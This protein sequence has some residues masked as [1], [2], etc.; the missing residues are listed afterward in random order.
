VTSLI[1]LATI[2]ALVIY[3]QLTRKDATENAEHREAAGRRQE[4][5][6]EHG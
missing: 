2:L 4:A 5:A 6:L 1:F 3:L